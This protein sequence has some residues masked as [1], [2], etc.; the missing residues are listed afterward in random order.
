MVYKI[1]F[2]AFMAIFGFTFVPSMQVA[3]QA[4]DSSN[5]IVDPI[6]GPTAA[7]KLTDKAKSSWPWYVTR[8]SGLVAAVLLFVLM[9]AGIGMITGHS[10][11]FLDPLIAWA[12]H[13]AIGI[14]FIVAIL[15]HMG[16]LLFDKFAPF[17]IPDLLVPFVSDYKPVSIAGFNVGSLYV[18]L[19]VV[20]F[21][22][23]LFIVLTSLFWI[24]KKPKLWRIIHYLTYLTMV[25]VF[26]H[27][28]LIGTDLAHG[29][30]RFLWVLGGIIIAI[31]LI[32]RLKRA[33]NL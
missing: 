19:G 13:R 7:E 4:P 15:V 17:K 27:A 6:P 12:T 28:L 18:A 23:V 33:K 16:A 21:W 8:G 9:L 14:A 2:I 10:F 11:K 5:I 31:I 1:I 32:V 22:S 20:A 26:I 30:L 3:A 25:A 24:N 29:L